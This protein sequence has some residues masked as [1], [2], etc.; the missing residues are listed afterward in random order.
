MSTEFSCPLCAGADAA[1]VVTQPDG[2]TIVRCLRCALVSVHP[3]PD[4]ATLLAL[5]SQADYFEGHSRDGAGYEAYG[6]META[7]SAIDR[8]RLS[9]ISGLCR[10]GHTLLDVGCAYGFFLR[11]AQAA[12]WQ[13]TGVEVSPHAASLVNRTGNLGE[14]IM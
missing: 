5:Y 8:Q 6:A 12:R 1:V 13:A 10:S 2:R 14:R 11:A 3:Q 7:D 4:D 9:A